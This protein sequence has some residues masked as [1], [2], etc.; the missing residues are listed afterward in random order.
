[1]TW[2][3]FPEGDRTRLVLTHEGIETFRGDLHP[4]MKRENFM[5]WTHVLDK[6]LKDFVEN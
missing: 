1:V 3:L 5:G 2:E 6:M 4:E